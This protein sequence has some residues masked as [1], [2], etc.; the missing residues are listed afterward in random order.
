MSKC[1][2]CNMQWIKKTAANVNKT[3]VTRAG[4]SQLGGVTVYVVPSGITI[5]EKI[6]N[7]GPFF[8]K[9]FV[10]WFMKLGDRCVC[11]GE[12]NEMYYTFSQGTRADENQIRYTLGLPC[13]W[14]YRCAVGWFDLDTSGL[15]N[16]TNED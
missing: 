10:A 7:D 4:T 15:C 2:F 11:Q 6:V 12:Q 8:N 9:Y 5:P 13:W 1:N 16:E 14:L 3:V